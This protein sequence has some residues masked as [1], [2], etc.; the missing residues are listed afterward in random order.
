MALRHRILEEAKEELLDA[1]IYHEQQRQGLGLKVFAAYDAII[2]HA[3]RFPK[4]GTP[5]DLGVDYPV[6]CFRMRR[7][8]YTIFAAVVGEQFVVFSVSHHKREPGYWAER[9]KKLGR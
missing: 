5:V 4:S 2:D 8:R 6:S 1:A 9:L 7:F 3:L